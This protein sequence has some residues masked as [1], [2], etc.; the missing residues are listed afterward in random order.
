MNHGRRGMVWL[1]CAGSRD[2][3]KNQCR[4][5]GSR[6]FLETQLSPHCVMTDSATQSAV[7]APIGRPRT[8]RQVH[9][10]VHGAAWQ[11]GGVWPERAGAG[12]VAGRL[13]GSQGVS[14]STRGST[15]VQLAERLTP[16]RDRRLI[17]AAIRNLTESQ[18]ISVLAARRSGRR[19]SPNESQSRRNCCNFATRRT[20]W[21]SAF[22]LRQWA[23][24]TVATNRPVALRT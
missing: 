8:C 21:E 7:S 1:R 13:P 23:F 19:W 6:L 10:Q 18:G 11:C 20:R 17:P 16:G 15:Y 14:A 2:V 22:G 3:Q 12:D 24:G 4:Y 9:L 5:S